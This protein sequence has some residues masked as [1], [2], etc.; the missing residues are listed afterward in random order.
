MK[1]KRIA[2][3]ASGSG[4]NAQNIIEYFAEN[5]YVVIEDVYSGIEIGK[6][7]I[8]KL[9]YVKHSFTPKPKNSYTLFD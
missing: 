6:K 8:E 5:E 4:T 7:M 9:G 1:V 3:F 2:L